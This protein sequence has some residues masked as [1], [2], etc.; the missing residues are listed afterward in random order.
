MDA[1]EPHFNQCLSADYDRD[2][3]MAFSSKIAEDL[4]V[5]G[6]GLSNSIEDTDIYNTIRAY[7]KCRFAIHIS[8]EPPEYAHEYFDMKTEKPV[9]KNKTHA[10]IITRFTEK[11]C[12]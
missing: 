10:L 5:N 9:Y 7:D 11:Y 1:K 8:T 12:S 3:I 2:T 4:K 6:W